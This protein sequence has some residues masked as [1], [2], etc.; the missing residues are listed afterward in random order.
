MT[1]HIYLVK[2]THIEEKNEI[3]CYFENK[4]KKIAQ[5]FSF[6]PNMTLP[7]DIS[8]DKLKELLFFY[9]IKN[10]DLTNNGNLKKIICKN[11]DDLKKINTLIAK[12]TNKKIIILEPERNFLVDKN[13]SYFDSFIIENNE[14]KKSNETFD[15]SSAIFK[16]ISFLEA[17][18]ISEEETLFLIKKS[19][20]SNLIKLPIEKTPIELKNIVEVFL[21][22]LFFSSFGYI[23]WNN[24]NKIYS[25]I[26]LGPFGMFEKVSQIDFSPVWIQLITNNFFNIS[27]ETIN[28]NCCKP[29]KLD[30]NNLLPSTLIEV[31]VNEDNFFFEST[32]NTFSID[33]HKNNLNKEKRIFKKKEFWLKSIPVGP[34][35][36]NQIIKIPLVDAKKLINNEFV[37]LSK[38]HELNWFCLKKEGFLSKEVKT[39]FEYLFNLNKKL[40]F[41]LNNNSAIL[42]DIDDN[43]KKVYLD[44]LIKEFSSILNEIPFQLSSINSM[45]FDQKVANAVISI[46]DSTIAK[47]NEFSE[48]KGY[49]VLYSNKRSA[50]IRGYLSLSL[51]KSFA[52]T[53]KLPQP[54]VSSFCAITKFR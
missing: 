9:N 25:K 53:L 30:D 44:I 24:E 37:K 33:F 42:I 27:Y 45:F 13:W 18:K 50:F 47:F 49:R 21:E 46:Q 23:S 16:E 11:Y 6:F 5:K 35:F 28:C 19:A 43:F 34:F 4:N 39:N 54:R 17:K 32:S 7:N 14:L 40:E 3:I 31:I 1:Q 2:V 10:F 36:K 52:S 29:I 20:I 51:A 8:I 12:L 22:N 48:E 38:E 15:Y 41:I 26:E